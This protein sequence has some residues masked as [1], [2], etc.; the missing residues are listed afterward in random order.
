M[1]GKIKKARP[2][3]DRQNVG[4]NV[5]LKKTE[6]KVIDLLLANPSATSDDLAA[7][8][9]VTKRTVERAYKTL[10]EKKVIKRIGSRRNGTWIV[11]K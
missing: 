3:L 9:G 4:L 8:I 7:K 5:G 10:Q 6:Q 2:A 11:M 1:K